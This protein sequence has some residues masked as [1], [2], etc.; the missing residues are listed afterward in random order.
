MRRKAK[1]RPEGRFLVCGRS[2]C[3]TEAATQIHPYRG[4]NR[5]RGGETYLREEG[6]RGMARVEQQ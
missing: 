3:L 5:G 6:L 2:W 1:N 4:T